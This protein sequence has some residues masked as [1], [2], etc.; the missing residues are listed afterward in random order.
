MPRS[1]CLTSRRRARGTARSRSHCPGNPGRSFCSR[2][3]PGCHHGEARLDEFRRLQREARQVDPAPRALDLDPDDKGQR[4]QRDRDRKTDEGDPPDRARRQQRHPEHDRE[5][6]RR[7]HQL[8]L[9]EVQRSRSRCRSA[10]AGLAAMLITA[11]KPMQQDERTEAP[12][13]DGPPPARDRRSGRC[14]RTSSR[15]DA[16]PLAAL[17]RSADRARERRRRAPRNRRTG[18]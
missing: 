15:G 12:A 10:T 2:E 3:Q 11:P 14:G 5:S 1:G 9:D 7:D 17:R 13:V 18:R 8:A 16:S 6:D 4:E